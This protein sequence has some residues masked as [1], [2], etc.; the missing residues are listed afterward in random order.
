MIRSVRVVPYGVRA[1]VRGRSLVRHGWWVSLVDDC[2]LEGHGDAASWPGFGAVDAEIVSALHRVAPSLHG[3]TLAEAQALVRR[4]HVPSPSRHALQLALCD[5]DAQQSRAPLADILQPGASRH[6][7]THA[8]VRTSEQA[9]RARL[10]GFTHLKVKVDGP[11][12]GAAARVEEV[13]EAGLPM[14]IDCNAGW[15]VDRA[16]AFLRRISDLP[17]D[18]VEQ[19]VV[20][21]DE[22]RSLDRC[23]VRIGADE[24]VCHASFDAVLDVADVVVIKPMFV[25]GPLE[26]VE[27]AKSA[28]AAGK[29]VVVTHAL[30]SRVGRRGALHVA[31]AVGRGVHGVGRIDATNPLVEIGHD[32]GLGIAALESAA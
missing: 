13:A 6:V 32:S 9:H 21:L 25:G 12:E 20:T 24:L 11:V 22:F 23:G 2:G 19:P 15:D 3:L 18:Y 27:L 5:L 16:N 30:E 14:R 26:A 31:A 1:Q 7:A 8:R 17:V 10:R 28:S 29:D 4:T